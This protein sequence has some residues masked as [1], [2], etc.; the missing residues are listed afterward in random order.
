V[1]FL[2]FDEKN[3]RDN[4]KACSCKDLD[5]INPSKPNL[6][7]AGRRKLQMLLFKEG[8]S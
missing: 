7:R 6:V 3:H 1:V 2:I 4:D 8:L 5:M